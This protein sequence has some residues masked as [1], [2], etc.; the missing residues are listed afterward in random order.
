MGDSKPHLKLVVSIT[1]EAVQANL[2]RR[3]LR[4]RDEARLLVFLVGVAMLAL[5]GLVSV[6]S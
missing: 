6:F 4:D 1:D 5:L 3:R 2:E